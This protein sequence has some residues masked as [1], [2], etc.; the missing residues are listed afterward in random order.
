MAA[1]VSHQM[2]HFD[3]S[4]SL[5]A[6]GFHLAINDMPQPAG[7]T[8]EVQAPGANEAGVRDVTS[9]RRLAIVA[10]GDYKPPV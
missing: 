5:S 6:R 3:A 10:R 8:L 1:C 7:R 4:S 2:P 9:A